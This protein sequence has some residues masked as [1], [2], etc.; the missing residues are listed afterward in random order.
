MK[1]IQWSSFMHFTS[2]TLWES[3]CSECWIGHRIGEWN[4]KL[5]RIWIYSK[6]INAFYVPS[7][8]PWM[9]QFENECALWDD[10]ENIEYSTTRWCIFHE[11]YYSP[12]AKWVTSA[13][14]T[15]LALSYTILISGL[16]MDAEHVISLWW[17]WWWHFC[18][19]LSALW[20]AL[21]VKD[22]Q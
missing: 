5:N 11:Q 1:S 17:G 15:C 12:D 22:L 3:P 10:I 16:M 7:T 2:P 21:V 20:H 13:S 9:L 18:W 8:T 6:K 14:L 19:L 4:E